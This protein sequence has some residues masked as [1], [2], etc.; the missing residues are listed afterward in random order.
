MNKNSKILSIYCLHNIITDE[1]YVGQTSKPIE[2]RWKQHQR[3]SRRE[4][5]QH[6]PLYRAIRKYGE[7]NFELL[8]LGTT[9][10]VEQSD[11]LEKVWIILLQSRV[12]VH[13]Y[14]I[15]EGGQGKTSNPLEVNLKIGLKNKGKT[16]SEETR[17]KMSLVR[18]GKKYG[19]YRNSNGCSGRLLSE[20]TK[21]KIGV[22]S[23][24]RM[25]GYKHSEEAKEKIRLS[26]LGN[27]YRVNGKT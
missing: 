17:K 21:T 13:G 6:Y 4:R 11:N 14:N 1:N 5:Y 15:K 2:E 23:Q 18:L 27:H 10:S 25:L 12:H 19:P 20:E 22:K 3:D 7:N 26:A 16:R 8:F 9:N 24:G